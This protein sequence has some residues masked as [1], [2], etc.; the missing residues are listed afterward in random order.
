MNNV[1]TATVN[2]I[3]IRQACAED[4]HEIAAFVDSC[5]PYLSKHVTHLHLIY[6]RYFTETCF[7]A[8]DDG[9][10]VGWCSVLPVGRAAFSTNS[11]SLRRRVG[12]V[13]PS[14]YSRTS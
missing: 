2:S 8:I 9:Q 6:T 7:V 5:G 13:S 11:G 1:T 3:C 12:K 10:I 4:I 14:R